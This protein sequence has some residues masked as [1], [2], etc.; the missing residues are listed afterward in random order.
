MMLC[1]ASNG[2]TEHDYMCL[3]EVDFLPSSKA[4][5]A[6]FAQ[7]DGGRVTELGFHFCKGECHLLSQ[8]CDVIIFYIPPD[9][10][11]PIQYKGSCQKK[12]FF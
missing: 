7:T 10:K 11:L 8:P 1:D 9:A 4:E 2:T 3:A 6:N 5:F 12:M